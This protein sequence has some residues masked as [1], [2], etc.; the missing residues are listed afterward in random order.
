MRKRLSSSGGLHVQ[1]VVPSLLGLLTVLDGGTVYGNGSW[2]PSPRMELLLCNVTGLLGHQGRRL[3]VHA[4]RSR[5][6]VPD[7]RRLPGSLQ[8]DL[9]VDQRAP[10]ADL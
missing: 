3:P 4:R 1:V 9:A 10:R 2:A 5:G 7:R 8:V 6:G